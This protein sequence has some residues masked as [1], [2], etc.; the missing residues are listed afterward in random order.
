MS[1]VGR[2]LSHYRVVEEIG[3]GGMGVVYQARDE[4]LERDVAVKVLPPDTLTDGVARKRFRK[5][6]LSLSRLN[7]PNIGMVFDFDSQDGVD[8]IVMELIPGITLGERLREGALPESEVAQI[9]EQLA[10]G[11]SAAHA[12]GVIH[13]DLKPAN[14][15]ITPEGRVKLLDFGLA[16]AARQSSETVST[17][18]MTATGQVMGTVPYMSPEQLR[19]ERVDARSD[20][21]SLG[22]VL[23]EMATGLRP[24]PQ[25]SQ[26]RV[27]SAILSEAPPAPRRVR[28][29]LTPELERVVLKCLEKERE[30]RYG[31]AAELATDLRRLAQPGAP[32]VRGPV[33]RALVRRVAIGLIAAAVVTAGA[34]I[35]ALDVGGLRGK[36][37]RQAVT[38]A[39]PSLAVLPLANLSGDASQE[40]FADGMTDEIITRLAQVRALKVISRTSAMQYKGTKKAPPQ[41]AK[42]LGVRMLVEGTVRRAGDRVRISAELIEAATQRSVWAETFERSLTDVFAVQSEIARAVVEQLRARLTP[43]E[44]ILIAATKRVDPEA[45]EEYL[46]GL[47]ELNWYEEDAFQ[48]ARDHFQRAIQIDPGYALAHAGLGLTYTTYSSLLLPPREAMPRAR[49]EAQAALALDSTLAEAH[50]VLGYVMALYDWNWTKAEHELRRGV[51]LYPS[52][53]WAHQNLGYYLTVTSRFEEARREFDR[54]LDLDP[55]SRYAATQTTWPLYEGRRYVEA[56]AQADRVLELDPA[57]W[58]ARMVRGQALVQLGRLDEAID[59]MERAVQPDSNA[60]ALA[61][62]VYALA[63]AKQTGRAHTVLSELERRAS[64][65]FVASYAMAFAYA[66]LGDRDRVFAWLEKGLEDRSEDMVFLNVDPAWD[67]LRS[68]PRFKVILRR[69][70]FKP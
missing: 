3:A 69:M 70:G 46:K 4:R 32:A 48:R 49:A 38:S 16:Q 35:L 57:Q 56:V 25:E 58:T 47:Y 26:P 51:E 1:L 64:K 52:N 24:F 65:G 29:E 68:D 17:E 28:G 31:S 54:A 5:E 41:I 67:S 19:G 9:G 59:T 27:I 45:H 39:V 61:N 15:R 2:S 12:Q 33:S 43:E 66:G 23:Y 6:A 30:R 53:A 44:R 36:L 55:L 8:F 20:L 13:R 37:F 22:S 34:A 10:E 62:L 40:Y 60:S 14:V 42:E 63:R 7:H 21:F 18:S 50:G 11:L